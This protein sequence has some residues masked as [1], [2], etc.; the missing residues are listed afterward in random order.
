MTSRG[1]LMTSWGINDEL[2]AAINDELRVVIHD[3]LGVDINQEG[4]R[5]GIGR[6]WDQS[7]NRKREKQWG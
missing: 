2:E 5:R 1:S 3:E 6:G 4:T 7:A